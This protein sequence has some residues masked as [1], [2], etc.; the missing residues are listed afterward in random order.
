MRKITEQSVKAFMNDRN[1]KSGNTEVVATTCGT[2]SKLFLH[3]NKIARKYG[4]NVYISS[5]GWQTVTTKERLNG[6]CD[7]VGDVGVNQVKGVWYR[8]NE[9]FPLNEWV[10]IK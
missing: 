5:A 7:M 6:V 1:F 2:F 3:G 9:V 4:D 8:G 10:Q